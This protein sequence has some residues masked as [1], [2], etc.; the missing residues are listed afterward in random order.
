M[1]RA[2]RVLRLAG[3]HAEQALRAD[4]GPPAG[5]VFCD[6]SMKAWSVRGYDS[7]LVRQPFIQFVSYIDDNSI[8]VSSTT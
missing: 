1:W 6:V 5:D 7:F 3:H 2:P 8:R 4:C